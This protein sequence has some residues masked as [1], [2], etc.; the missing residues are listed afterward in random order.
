MRRAASILLL[1]SLLLPAW[2]SVPRLRS[3]LQLWERLRA[4]DRDGPDSGWDRYYAQLKP[5]LPSRGRIGIVQA[6]APHTTGQEREYYFLQYALA[7]RLLVPGSDAEFVIACGPPSAAAT[8]LDLSK[9]VVV[10][11]FYDDFA[12]YRRVRP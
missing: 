3:H 5:Y 4:R 11:Q 12:L 8:L 6:A 9:F 2:D 10:R 1:A 7:P